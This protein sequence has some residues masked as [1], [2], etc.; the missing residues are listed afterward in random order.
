MELTLRIPLARQ[1]ILPFCMEKIVRILSVSE[2]LIRLM[3][4]PCI[5]YPLLIIGL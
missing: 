1:T 3:T 5:L 4:T 2:K